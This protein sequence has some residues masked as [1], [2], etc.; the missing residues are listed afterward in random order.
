MSFFRRLFS[1][2][3]ADDENESQQDADSIQATSD[4]SDTPALV[5]PIE[6][7][8]E[9]SQDNTNHVAT[10]EDATTE[11]EIVSPERDIADTDTENTKPSASNLNAPTAEEYIPHPVEGVTRPLERDP[12]NI[13]QPISGHLTFAHS[14]DQGLTRNN[15]Q[16][17]VYRFFASNHSVHNM[18]DVGL[19][20]VADGMGGHNNGEKAS[21][22]TVQFIATAILKSL[23]VPMLN[24]TDEDNEE[25]FTISEVLNHAVK[26]ANKRVIRTIPD[27]G[28]TLTAVLVLGDVAHI[29]HVG[30]SRAYLIH[31][32]KI[33]QLTRDHSLA[34][35]LIE[36]NQL[37]TEDR[38][39]YQHRNVLYRA[40]GHNEDLEV[41]TMIRRLPE[42]AYVL[43]CSD[44]LWGE[45]SEADMLRII[46]ESKSLQEAC[47]TMIA[48]ANRNGG[49]DNIT[50]LLLKT[51][52]K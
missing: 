47:D 48:L 22:T 7:A 39:D 21:A 9:S 23:Y 36:L 20:M 46:R 18:P 44:G 50:V 28:T 41:D 16:D 49:H 34:Q 32:G 51:P 5:E 12:F 15:N 14:S 40:I 4:L 24:K 38:S 42:S 13:Y 2:K 17:S 8:T 11:S 30:D 37:S 25:S 26:E 3:P 52:S 45:I 29:A 10:I 19:F 33:E 6:E 1:A 35:R 43:L 27:G 31:D